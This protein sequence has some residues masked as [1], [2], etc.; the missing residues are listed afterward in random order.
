VSF[1]GFRYF[2]RLH[3]LLLTLSIIIL[4]L[5]VSVWSAGDIE[6]QRVRAARCSGR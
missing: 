5:S 2:S 1:G 4:L 3:T 6:G